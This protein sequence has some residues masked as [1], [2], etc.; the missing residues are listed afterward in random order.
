MTF[1]AMNPWRTSGLLLL[2]LGGTSLG[3]FSANFYG[4]NTD[5]SSILVGAGVLIMLVSL[6]R[7]GFPAAIAMVVGPVLLGLGT[8]WAFG[9]VG[10]NP[11]VFVVGMV[12]VIAGFVL[13]IFNDY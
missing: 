6:G 5:I 1:G 13:R 8:A 3:V 7:S 10:L 12:G 11:V 2:M 4:M 9:T